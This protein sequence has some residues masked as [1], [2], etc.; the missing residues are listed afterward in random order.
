MNDINSQACLKDHLYSATTCV[1][2]SFIFNLYKFDLCLEIM[3][4]LP[5]EWSLKRSLTC[6]K[7]PPVLRDHAWTLH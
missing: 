1:K 3:L 6:I 4:R 2:T 7:R 5:I